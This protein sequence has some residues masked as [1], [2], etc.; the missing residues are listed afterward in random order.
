MKIKICT[1]V[2]LTLINITSLTLFDNIPENNSQKYT[3]IVLE[4]YDVWSEPLSYEHTRKAFGFIDIDFDRKPEFLVTFQQGSGYYSTTFCYDVDTDKRQLKNIPIYPESAE[5]Q[6]DI[7]NGIELYRDKNGKEFYFVVDYTRVSSDFYGITYRTLTFE[8]N[9]I[10]TTPVF[11]ESNE[12][13]EKVYYKY[14][15]GKSQKIS[16]EE[17]EKTTSDFYEENV[18]TDFKYYFICDKEL[19]DFVNSSEEEKKKQLI[20]S[21][22]EFYADLN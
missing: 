10:V 22:E 14:N 11:V 12:Y 19:S 7:A 8:N 2:I 16:A 9:R 15:R 13:G 17:Y 5:T 1:A 3:E 4:N 6:M 21:Y 20:R 18:K